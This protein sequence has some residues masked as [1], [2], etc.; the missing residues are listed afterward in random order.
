MLATSKS[1][2]RSS[3]LPPDRLGSVTSPEIRREHG[4]DLESPRLEPVAAEAGAIDGGTRDGS[5]LAPLPEA[6]IDCS[7]SGVMNV[8]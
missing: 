5:S 3:L 8:L 4:R 1:R 7:E 2:R 6:L